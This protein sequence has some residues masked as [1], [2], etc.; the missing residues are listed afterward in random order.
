MRSMAR[1]ILVTEIFI[2]ATEARGT[3]GD[4]NAALTL[5]STDL[6]RI[7]LGLRPLHDIW[8]SA[9]QA[10]LAGWMLYNHLGVVFVVPMALVLIC[11]ACLAILMKFT[12]DS[13]RAWMVSFG[14]AFRQSHQLI[15]LW[16]RE[17]NS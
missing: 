2:K 13:Q 11:V 5:M 7:N 15:Y 6:E 1:S 4:D 3:T 8:A 17:S 12:G 10:A 14:R 9:I 16:S